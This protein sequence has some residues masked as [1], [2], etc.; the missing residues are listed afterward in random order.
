[1]LVKHVKCLISYIF[2]Y[3]TAAANR[4]VIN[5]IPPYKHKESGAPLVS[6]SSVLFQKRFGLTTL[7][8][9]FEV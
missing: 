1:M 7:M 9:N 8:C 3:T 5:L 6:F 2:R 4:T